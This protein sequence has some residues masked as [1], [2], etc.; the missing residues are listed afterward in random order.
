MKPTS[1]WLLRTIL[2][3]CTLLECTGVVIAFSS[4]SSSPVIQIARVATE[5]DWRDFADLRYDEWIVG[6]DHNNDGRPTPTR[7]AFRCATRD[8]YL[9]ERPQS[10]LFLAKKKDPSMQDNKRDD[11]AMTSSTAAGGAAEMSPYEVEAGWR[12]PPKVQEEEESSLSSS[13]T[14]T[15]GRVFYVTDVVTAANCRRQGIARQMMIDLEKCAKEDLGVTHLVLNVKDDN[16]PALQFYRR[17]GYLDPTQ[18]LLE[19]LDVSKLE[20][21]AGTLGQLL[22]GKKL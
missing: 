7:D 14:P 11:T 4:S 17:L 6:S 15:I 10:I 19:V 1:L 5:Q 18:E 20:E 9:E 3:V 16:I 13:P 21:E 2:L 12:L 22:L 8:I